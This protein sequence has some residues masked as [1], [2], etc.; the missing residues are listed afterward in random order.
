M[1][2]INAFFP[3]VI[4]VLAIV[5]CQEVEQ[6]SFACKDIDSPYAD[7]TADFADSSCKYMYPTEF[8]ITYFEDKVWDASN[9]LFSEADIVL[10]F[11]EV[12]LD[13]VYFTSLQISNADPNV[14]HRWVAHAPFKFENKTYTW[15]LFNEANVIIVESDELMT[16][17]LLNPLDFKND[18][19]IVAQDEA[20]T[21]QIKIR[22]EI[23]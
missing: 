13:S 8:E 5:G 10:Q 3:F 7:M 19:V 12:G 1:K 16:S 2:Y 6:P 21:T 20:Q 14:A 15:Q 4:C 23:R 18:S 9:P 11:S 22:Y 17:G